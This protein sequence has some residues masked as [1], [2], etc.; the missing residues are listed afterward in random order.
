MA[1]IP[2]QWSTFSLSLLILSVTL[3]QNRTPNFSPPPPNYIIVFRH[4]A[5]VDSHRI[6]LESALRPEGWRWIPRQ[7]PAAQ[8]PTDFGLVAIEDSGVVDEIRKLGS[9]KY[10][11]LDMSYKRSLMTKDQR[12]NKK[13]GAF[14]NGTEQRRGKII[15]AMSFCEA[16]EDEESVGNHSSSVKWGRELMMQVKTYGFLMLGIWG[17][18]KDLN[19]DL[20]SLLMVV[21]IVLSTLCNNVFGWKPESTNAM[22][23]LYY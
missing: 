3:F 2:H 21:G 7:N 6:Y 23:K 5:A 4:Y 20:V 11:S 19:F 12:C 10:V 8:F 16:E 18:E 9:V 15:T 22:W 14:E 1:T 17:N 13:V